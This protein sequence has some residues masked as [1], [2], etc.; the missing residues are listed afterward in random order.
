M[1][2]KKKHAPIEQL[3]QAGKI[4]ED[5]LINKYKV[6]LPSDESFIESIKRSEN[7]PILPGGAGSLVPKEYIPRPW[8]LNAIRRILFDIVKLWEVEAKA[9]KVDAENI[10]DFIT[11]VITELEKTENKIK[12]LIKKTAQEKEYDYKYFHQKDAVEGVK[13]FLVDS[14]AVEAIDL[15]EKKKI[16]GFL[17]VDHDNKLVGAFNLHDLLKAK[18]L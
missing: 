5:L 9:G 2:R 17:V 6:L 11:F 16:T 10:T 18:L 15:M 8:T 7:A 12:K 4:A 14:L 3:R 1:A 13:V